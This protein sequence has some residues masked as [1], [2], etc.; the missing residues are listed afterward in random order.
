MNRLFVGNIP[1][2]ASEIDLRKW[3]TQKGF[4][5]LKAEIV[6]DRMSGHSRGFGFVETEETLNEV[7]EIPENDRR[8]SG[9]KLTINLAAPRLPKAEHE[10]KK[11][12]QSR[13]FDD[14][15]I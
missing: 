3:F 7:L 12:R 6:R 4:T 9:R 11:M 10:R 1:H 14:A 15:D 13:D 5:V 2:A 8:M